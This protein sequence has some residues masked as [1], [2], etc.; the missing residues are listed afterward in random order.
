M[1][2]SSMGLEEFIYF[3]T[4]S[5]PQ[6]KE[7]LDQGKYLIRIDLPGRKH[8]NMKPGGQYFTFI[9]KD[10]IV[11]L[12]NYLEVRGQSYR[13]IPRKLPPLEKAIFITENWRPLTKFAIMSYFKRHAWMLGMT[14]RRHSDKY[15]R[16]RVHVHEMRDTFRT[17]WN[18]TDAKGFMAEFFMGHVID[19]NNYN[20]PMKMPEWAEKQYSLAEPYLNI[21][22][23]DPRTIKR[24]ALEAEIEKRVQ[25]RVEN[26]NKALK[27]RM[28]KMEKKITQ[29]AEVFKKMP[30]DDE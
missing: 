27:E 1:Y 15:A 18:L 17:E 3:N 9:G 10:A 6:V 20:K 12:R 19:S 22:S 28:E 29:L 8:R 2:Q 30:V 5:W 24:V 7:Q 21:L 4:H 11:K 26:E 13:K 23:E 25:A 16:Y 14:K